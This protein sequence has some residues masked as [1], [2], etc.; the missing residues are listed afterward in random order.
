MG[1]ESGTGAAGGHLLQKELVAWLSELA[2][3]AWEP[4]YVV[5]RSRQAKAAQRAHGHFV[6]ESEGSRPPR[7]NPL[8]IDNQ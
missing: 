3:S 2:A 4:A 8:Q 7:T 6:S 1:T 5:E